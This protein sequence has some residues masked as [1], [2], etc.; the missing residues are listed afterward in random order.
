MAARKAKAK[1]GRVT[2]AT[3]GRVKKVTGGRVKKQVGGRAPVKGPNV[4][5]TAAQKRG[6]ARQG[7]PSAPPS[8]PDR[9]F[10]PKRHR[11]QTG[12]WRPGGR[13]GGKVSKAKGGRVSKARGGK[14]KR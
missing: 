5:L 9:G 11:Q 8:A 13:T 3:G 7:R 10:D 14:A 2:K 12:E 1:G 6:V 4:Q